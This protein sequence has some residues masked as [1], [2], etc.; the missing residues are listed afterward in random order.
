M[1]K[2]NKAKKALSKYLRKRIE[3]NGKLKKVSKKILLHLLDGSQDLQNDVYLTIHTDGTLSK[4][5]CEGIDTNIIDSG[6]TKE[7][8]KTLGNH[9]PIRLVYRLG[10][11]QDRLFHRHLLEGR[12]AFTIWLGELIK[13]DGEIIENHIPITFLKLDVVPSLFSNKDEK[14]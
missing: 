2:E 5:I 11:F 9:G 13:K 6:I 14:K 1:N 12:F 3:D 4:E 8:N 7:I 10:Y